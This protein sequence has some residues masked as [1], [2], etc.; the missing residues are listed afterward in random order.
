M[1]RKPSVI[2]MRL[3]IAGVLSLVWMGAGCGE[4]TTSVGKNLLTNPS[5]ED[6]VDGV[7]VGWEVRNVKG[8]E[9]DIPATWGIDEEHR[10]DGQ[11]SFFFQADEETRRF[12]MLTQEVEVNNIRRIRVRGAIRTLEAIRNSGQYPLSSFFL[13]FYDKDR[14]RFQS[15]RFYDQR[16]TNRLGT[17]D[18][19]TVV[20]R[21]FRVP[22]NTRYVAF[23]CV[24]GMEGKIWFDDV[25]LDVPTDLPWVTSKTE[26]FTFHWL[27]GSEYPEGSKDFQQELFD[28]Y[29][30]RL[31]ISR[32]ERPTVSTYFYPDSV[33]LFETVGTRMLKRSYWDER[34]I[35]SIYPVDDHEIIHIITKPYG[36]L[37]LALTEGT[38]FYLI[39][40]YKGRPILSIAQ[41]LLKGDGLPYL[42]DIL[43]PGNMRRMNPDVV[44]ATAASFVG[45]LLELGGPNKF[46]ELHREANAVKRPA[47]FRKAF[48]RVYDVPMEEAE[49]EWR[50]TLGRLDFSKTVPPK[51]DSAEVDH[52]P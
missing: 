15:M 30:S 29:C 44:A 5:F 50:T 36:I 22:D 51:P 13:T 20:D 34:E 27:A 48:E 14:N 33:T 16:T 12:Y 49:E 40:N 43:D 17:S 24:F 9:T 6:I 46:L 42:D 35:H 1:R 25:S 18:G 32:T 21:T 11:R 47:D 31:G 52:Q 2:C 45:Y 7:P 26:N 39:V 23:H 19:W 41:D 3:V 28:Y 37:P 4:K 8:L 10:Y 38:A